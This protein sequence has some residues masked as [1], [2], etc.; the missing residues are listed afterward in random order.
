MISAVLESVNMEK[1]ILRIGDIVINPFVSKL[2]D[3]K[4]NPNYATIY[5]GN[6]R[7]VDYKGRLCRWAS[8]IRT[9][10]PEWR[11]IG[12]HDFGLLEVISQAI[13]EDENG[14]A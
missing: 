3:G 8:D 13:E 2:F 10:K 12:H 5:I 11:V 7:T 9:S 6:N 1:R 4:L 14:R